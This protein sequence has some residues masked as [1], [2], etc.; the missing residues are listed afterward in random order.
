MVGLGVFRGVV[1]DE[2]HSFRWIKREE[3]S[4]MCEIKAN[5]DFR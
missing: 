5:K 1:E 3:V 4:E 2:N